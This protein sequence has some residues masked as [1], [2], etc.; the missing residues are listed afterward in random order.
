MINDSFDLDTGPLTSQDRNL[1]LGR[2][3]SLLFWVG[4][5]IPEEEM[6]EG[7]KVPLRDIVFHFVG[8]PDPTPEEVEAALSL[9]RVLEKRAKELEICLK[10]CPGLTKGKAHM[11]MDE[12]NGLLRAVDEIHH[13]KGADERVKAWALMS[14]VKDEKRWLSFIKEVY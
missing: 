9:A 11:M 6:L 3:H 7:Q 8:K 4:K 12:A 2:I 5:F 1:I 10:E 13:A 14:K